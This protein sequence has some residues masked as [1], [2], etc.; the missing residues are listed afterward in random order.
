MPILAKEVERHITE[1]GV[2]YFIVGVY[3]NFDHLAMKT[4]ITAKVRHP[5]VHLL[6][7]LPYHPAER[8]IEKPEGVDELY[9]PDGL[10]NA[11]RRYAIVKAN[12]IVIDKVDCLI[13]YVSHPASNAVKFLN[14]A[15]KR[16]SA[17]RIII[18]TLKRGELNER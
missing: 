14:Y 4:V 6:L 9:Y 18:T 5:E 2:S 15:R 12:Q 1:L 11:P 10:E 7:L 13:A 16:E 3:G 8:K 17:G